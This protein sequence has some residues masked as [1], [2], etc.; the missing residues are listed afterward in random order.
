MTGRRGIGI[1]LALLVGL[2]PGSSPASGEAIQPGHNA[3]IGAVVGQ[4]FPWRLAF[5]AFFPVIELRTG[6]N[7]IDEIL[8]RLDVG[9][10]GGAVSHSE[11]ETFE[12]ATAM[13]VN[14]E[15]DILYNPR[16]GESL[17]LHLGVGIGFCF[18]AL[19]GDNLTGTV[20]GTVQNYVE[21]TK[22]AYAAVAGLSWDLAPEWSL[23]LETRYTYAPMS[24]G[25]FSQDAGGLTVLAG[26]FYRLGSWEIDRPK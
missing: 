21:D 4:H 7:V 19:W 23:V 18:V 12:G 11:T 20:S 17:Q 13:L 9:G 6:Y 5:P 15:A 3:Q 10:G 2:A 14:L 25:G 8:V 1:A 16:L 22:A 26:F 24:P